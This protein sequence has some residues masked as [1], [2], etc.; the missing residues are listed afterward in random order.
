MKPEL[1]VVM[2]SVAPD[3]GI[4][5]HFDGRM[6]NPGHAIEAAWF[7]LREAAHRNDE[8]L[9]KLGCDMLDWM[10]HRGWRQETFP[11]VP[12]ILAVSAVQGNAFSVISG[13]AL[14]ANAEGGA[15]RTYLRDA[16]RCDASGGWQR[17]ADMPR[18]AVAAPS[19]AVASGASHFLVMGGDDGT[20]VGFQP[21][22]AHPGFQRSILAYDTITRTWS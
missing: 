22:S 11:G 17:I 4:S 21:P 2:E 14:A 16:W 12:R 6:L 15:V 1:N 9:T 8:A 18:P 10:W 7:V 3:G 19:P 13:A 5:N 20:R